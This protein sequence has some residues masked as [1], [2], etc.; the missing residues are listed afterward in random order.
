MKKMN[1]KYHIPHVWDTPRAVWEDVYLR[2]DVPDSDEQSVWLTIDAL[3]DASDPN[4][5]SD[6]AEF[7]K[8]ALAKLGENAY[9][10][11]GA[12]MIVRVRDFS[13]EEFLSWVKV[14]L[15]H[16]GLPV[17]D[18]VEA[19]FTEFAGTNPHAELLDAIRDPEA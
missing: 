12:D 15:E 10:T 8:E 18:L 14:W 17:T 2:P 4:H 1:W 3:G 11:D 13:K 5:G 9:W 6:R 19:P 7:Q 16:N